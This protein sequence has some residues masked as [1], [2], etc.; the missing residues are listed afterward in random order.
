MAAATTRRHNCAK[1]Q[2]MYAL[3]GIDICTQFALVP[4]AANAPLM[5]VMRGCCFAAGSSD[6]LRLSNSPPP[7]SPLMRQVRASPP[8]HVTLNPALC[9]RSGMYISA[10]ACTRWCTR[11]FV[12]HSE[13][14]PRCQDKGTTICQ[15]YLD[16]TQCVCVYSVY[17][18]WHGVQCACVTSSA[19]TGAYH[20]RHPLHAYPLRDTAARVTGIWPLS[21][22][23]GVQVMHC[24]LADRST[25]GI[26]VGVCCVVITIVLTGTLHKQF[27]VIPIEVIA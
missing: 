5:H 6:S 17:S 20:Y 15:P 18:V 21:R 7:E 3:P 14:A 4:Q 19:D 1:S 24:P 16:G 27:S 13:S 2:E 26:D 9:V 25:L 8:A 11:N 12:Y 23:V 10:I 22:L